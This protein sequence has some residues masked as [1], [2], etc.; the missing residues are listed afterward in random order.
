MLMMKR[1]TTHGVTLIE[2]LVAMVI[3]GVLAGGTLMV[4]LTAIQVA[5]QA[6]IGQGTIFLAQQTAERFR[7][8]IACQQ[9][10]EAAS[11][12]WYGAGPV[13]APTPPVG[14][15]T[16]LV[17]GATYEVTPVDCDGDAIVGDCL[18]MRVRKN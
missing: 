11:D 2:I 16:D 6:G 7:N 1:S 13:C 8:K 18:E 14:A 3:L 15:Q 12:T 17:T 9:L 5:K 10:G 4:F